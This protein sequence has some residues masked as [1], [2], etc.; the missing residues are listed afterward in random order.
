ME[1]LGG[2]YGEDAGTPLCSVCFCTYDTV[3]HRP[4]WASGITVRAFWLW[5]HGW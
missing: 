1:D 3:L 5:V 2:T 4:W